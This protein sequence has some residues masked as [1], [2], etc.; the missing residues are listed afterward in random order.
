MFTGIIEEIGLIHHLS[1]KSDIHQ[2]K[3]QTTEDFVAEMVSGDSI[4]VNGVCLTAYQ[5]EKNAFQVDVSEETQKCTHFGHRIREN[6]VN[7][8]HAV[9][10]STRM[11]G[12]FVS[13]HVDGMGIAN[14]RIDKENESI[15]W[16]SPPKKLIRYI[17]AK[18]SICI[19]GVSLTVND[20][21]NDEFSV[22]IIPHTLRNT[23]LKNVK[24]KDQVNI[25][26][27]LVARY[28]EQITKS[29]T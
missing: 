27:D 26:V 4:A 8:E 20:T 2:Y 5:I 19:N 21:N 14:K 1:S 7:L 11:G 29:T 25:E 28:L 10:P 12:H 15:F 23:T 17:A 16:F 3:I 13:G 22:T 18:G 24:T 9:T 6:H